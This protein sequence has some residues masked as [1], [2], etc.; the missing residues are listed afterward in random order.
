[1]PLPLPITQSTLAVVGA[2]AGTPIAVGGIT[3]TDALLALV[4]WRAHEAAAALDIAAFVVL[5][6]AIQSTTIDTSGYRLALVW[7]RA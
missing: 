7:A 1:V 6:G 4:K 5:N 2:P 3:A